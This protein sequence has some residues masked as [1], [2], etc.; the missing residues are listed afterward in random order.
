MNKF[1]TKKTKKKHDNNQFIYKFR[2]GLLLYKSTSKISLEDDFDE[3][4]I[5]EDGHELFQHDAIRDGAS[6]QAAR[7]SV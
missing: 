4:K 2:K 5:F 6:E 1:K 7:V 3:G